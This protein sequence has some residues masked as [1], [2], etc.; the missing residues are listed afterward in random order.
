[1]AAALRPGSSLKPWNAAGGGL[2]LPP[3]SRL[4]RVPP[5]DCGPSRLCRRII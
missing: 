3:P 5:R 4:L 1:M 2:P